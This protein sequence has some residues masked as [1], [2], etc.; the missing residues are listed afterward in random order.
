MSQTTFYSLLVPFS[1][2]VLGG[3]VVFLLRNEMPDG[4]ARPSGQRLLFAAWTFAI[5]LVLM[6]FAAFYPT[7]FAVYFI[8]W[9][10]TLFGV[11]PFGIRSQHEAGEVVRGSEPGAPELPAMKR[12]VVITTM[13][14]VPLFVE[15]RAPLVQSTLSDKDLYYIAHSVST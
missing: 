12:K 3:C 15:I 7:W 14:S 4:S 2:A 10:T 6:L 1:L 11:L 13:I 9:W 5:V 8:I